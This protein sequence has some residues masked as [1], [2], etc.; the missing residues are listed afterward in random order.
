MRAEVLGSRGHL[1]QAPNVTQGHGVAAHATP[2]HGDDGKALK[3]DSASTTVLL[4][5]HFRQNDRR[6]A[7]RG[8]KNLRRV[9]LP[10]R[11]RTAWNRSSNAPHSN[12]CGLP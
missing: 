4:R 10:L 3:R 12:R 5:A 1:G 9:R 7:S 2:W 6:E 8:G 11:G